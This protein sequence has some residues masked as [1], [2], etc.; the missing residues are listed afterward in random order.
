MGQV[1]R[2]IVPLAIGVAISPVPIIAV[3]LM[4]FTQ[5]AQANSLVFLLGWVVG[6]AGACT[7]FVW[8]SGTQDLS[9]AGEP[10]T[11][12]SWINVVV[13]VLLLL[14]ALRQWQSRPEPGDEAKGPRWM[15]RI[16]ALG[17]GIALGLGVLLS[18]VN[19]KNLLLTVKAG[20]SIGGAGLSAV[21]EAVA[22]AGFTLIGSITV[23]LPTIAYVV[24][25]ERAKPS[26]NRAKAWLL[27]KNAMVTAAL[28]A[29]L[30]VALL[31]NGIAGLL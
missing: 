15:K 26:L 8:L 9:T 20:V 28:L 27:L 5:R 10:S 31:G 7:L 4:L 22:I 12:A 25:G 18:A 14:A 19:P 3:I 6:L 2:E 16:D 30:G 1:M 17:P 29:V 24:A 23:A 13:G 21:D 11:A